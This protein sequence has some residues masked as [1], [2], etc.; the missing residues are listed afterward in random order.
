VITNAESGGDYAYDYI[1]SARRP[2]SAEPRSSRTS[3]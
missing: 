2:T 1:A 3:T